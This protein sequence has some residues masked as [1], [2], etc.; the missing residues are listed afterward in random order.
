MR[1][2]KIYFSKLS[3]CIVVMFKKSLFMFYFHCIRVVQEH[4][5]HAATQPPKYFTF[6]ILLTSF[7]IKFL[8]TPFCCFFEG[9]ALF[10]FK[11]Q[12]NK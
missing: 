10:Y 9:F 8:S 3:G 12:I 5:Y 7:E 6:H 4:A 1:C 11:T 2:F